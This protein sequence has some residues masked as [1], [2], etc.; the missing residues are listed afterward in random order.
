MGTLLVAGLINIETTL[1]VDAF[2]ID[3]APVRYPF[4]GVRSTVSGVGFNVAKALH[5]L[6]DAVRFLSLIGDDVGG[7]ATRSELDQIGIDTSNVVNKLDE[8]PQSVIL[9]TEDGRRA[10]H[11]DLK[12]IQDAA[13]PLDR[14]DAALSGCDMA[15][16]ANINFSRPMLHR[17]QKAGV[18]IATD[19]HAISDLNDDYNSDYMAAAHVLFQSHEHLPCDPAEWTRRVYERYNTPIIVV[20]IGGDGAIMRVHGG[21]PIHVPAVQV[22]PVV[23]TIGAGDSLF[24]SF[25]HSYVQTDNAVVALKKAVVFAGYKIGA[26]GGAD[27]FLSSA[28][29]DGWCNQIY[30]LGWDKS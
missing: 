24:S 7:M 29:L 1:K 27:G 11:T 12:D 16:V 23:N 15:V 3:Y 20:G 5:T 26:V 9:Y 4:F 6:G 10:I 28:V 21:E 19:V 30:G 2:P 8:T 14:F 17:A 22:R 13:Y 25:V 18:R